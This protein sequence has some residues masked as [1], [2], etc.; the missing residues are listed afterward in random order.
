[1][2]RQ[3]I[4]RLFVFT[5]C[6]LWPDSTGRA[7]QHRPAGTRYRFECV[8]RSVRCGKYQ[9]RQNH[10]RRQRRMGLQ[11]LCSRMG[12]NGHA[13]GPIG[14][15]Q[16]GFDRPSGAYDRVS[17]VEHTAGGTLHFSD[18][19]AVSVTEIPN[20]GSARSVTFAPKTVKWLRFE[21]TD[22]NGKNIGLS[23]IEVFP[24]RGEDTEY[25]EWVDLI[26][27]PHAGGGSSAHRQPA[28]WEW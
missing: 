11:R 7:G 23:E 22:G 17:Q 3:T 19:T 28:R 2:K 12:R 15:G 24:A 14:M 1:M 21:A 10:V 18:G 27:K 4:I 20:D 13:V 5:A 16:R 25:V 26:S 8:E 9:R 6:Y